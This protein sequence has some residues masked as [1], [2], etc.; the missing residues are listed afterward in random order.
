MRRGAHGRLQPQRPVWRVR[1]PSG[2][3]L[4]AEATA[5]PRGP[6]FALAEEVEAALIL[7]ARRKGTPEPWLSTCSPTS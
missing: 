1:R 6:R 5:S 2:P 7:R 4:L 3:V